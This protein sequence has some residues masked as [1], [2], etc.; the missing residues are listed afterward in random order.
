MPTADEILLRLN[1]L[2]WM[3]KTGAGTGRCGVLGV[4]Q[5]GPLDAA[6]RYFY[7]FGR[8]WAAIREMAGS[9]AEEFSS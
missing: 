1:L 3:I 9:I 6:S 2:D 5:I 4:R 7:S 8:E